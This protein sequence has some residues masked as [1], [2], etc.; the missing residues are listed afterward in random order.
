MFCQTE[1]NQCAIPTFNKGVL[2]T[3]HE[4]YKP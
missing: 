1:N 3:T 2:L 4:P